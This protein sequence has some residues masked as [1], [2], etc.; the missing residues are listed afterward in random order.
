MSNQMFHTSKSFDQDL[1]ETTDLFLEMGALAGQQVAQAMHAL[2]EGDMHLA[3]QVVE[4]DS[5]VNQLEVLID[6]RILLLVA[7][8]QPAARDLRYV[9][10]V[11]KGVVDIERIGD[12]AAKIAHMAQQ[13]AADNSGTYSYHEVQ[14]LSNQVRLMLHSALAAF[15]HLQVERAFDVMRSDGNV[16]FEYQ[17][18]MRAL[19]TYVME[20]PRQVSHVINLMWILRALERIGDHARNIA[21]L[22]IYISSGTDVRHSDFETVQQAIDASKIG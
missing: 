3:H 19:M 10:A 8:R 4:Q 7:K 15:E 21:E 2:I 6:E 5:A 20:D 17:S 18:A 22:V 16:D 9:M 11:S 13:V 14:H 1:T 12:E